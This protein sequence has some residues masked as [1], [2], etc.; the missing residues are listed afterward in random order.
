MFN[1]ILLG[2][3]G[4]GKGTQASKLKE[5]FDIPH[6]STGD[7][8]REN[9]KKGTEL[10]KKAKEYMDKGALVP[11]ELV[12]GIVTS[13]LSEDDCKNGFVL[14]GFPR[15][16]HQAEELGRYFEES[17]REKY[18]VV[19]I[20]VDKA[21]LI[22]RL[23]G[24]RLCKSCSAIYHVTGM[25]SKSQGICDACGGELYQRSDDNEETVANRTEVHN[26]QTKPLT[27]Y[28]D[29]KGNI[30]HVDGMIGLENVFAEIVKAVEA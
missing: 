12:I 11:D 14:D 2:P 16:V 9:I 19:D 3:P 28:Y 30:I 18:K 24:R 8:F 5:K 21:E 13:R 26:S 7:I 10:G 27:D 29:K 20:F 4:A 1:L 6:I 25:P 22:R 15:T 23:S 17:G